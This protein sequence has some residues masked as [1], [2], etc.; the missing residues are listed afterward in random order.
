MVGD[1]AA[2]LGGAGRAGNI[3]GRRGVVKDRGWTKERGRR[4]GAGEGI[5]QV[6]LMGVGVGDRGVR[7][8]SRGCE[9]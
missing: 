6:G 2:R 1:G 7:S 5:I 4:L 9:N 8:I 3:V